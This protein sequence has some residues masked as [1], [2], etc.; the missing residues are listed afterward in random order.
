MMGGN[1]KV[2]GIQAQKIPIKKIGLK[3][4][5][6]NVKI[7]LKE[8]NKLFYRKYK[9]YIWPNTEVLNNSYVFNGSTSY[10]LDS[11]YLRALPYVPFESSSFTIP[12]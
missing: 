7:L 6:D 1:V 5:Q 8:L 11:K 12:V 2:K 10:L 9:E 3:K 4:F